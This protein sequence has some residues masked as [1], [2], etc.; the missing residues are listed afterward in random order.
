[1]E[2]AK[3]LYAM[4]IDVHKNARPIGYCHAK[5]G[6]E[7]L[8][9]EQNRSCGEMRMAT[10]EGEGLRIGVLVTRSLH[11][12]DIRADRSRVTCPEDTAEQCTAIFMRKQAGDA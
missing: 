5:R 2:E 1:M 10:G 11:Q 7:G 4:I 6:A 8:K 9:S 3:F 12:C